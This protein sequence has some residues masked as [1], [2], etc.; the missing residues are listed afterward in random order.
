MTWRDRLSRTWPSGRSLMWVWSSTSSVRMWTGFTSSPD[1][2][3]ID[4][5]HPRP[6]QAARKPV[7]SVS[8][9]TLCVILVTSG[10]KFQR[11]LVIN[12]QVCMHL[13]Q[14]ACILPSKCPSPCKHPPPIFDMILWSRVY[15]LCVQM[16]SPCKCP[17]PFFWPVRKFQAPTELTREIIR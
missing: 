9:C 15:A 5:L 8:L 11:L 14:F 1:C 10:S 2:P 3:G 4:A 16:A 13:L 6:P 12:G 17:P 7:Y